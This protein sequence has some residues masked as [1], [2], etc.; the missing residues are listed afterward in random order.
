M[1]P[2]T[3]WKMAP[4]PSPS[5]RRR[6]DAA[7]GDP[8][9]P[10]SRGAFVCA[11]SESCLASSLSSGR[12]F[13]REL[14]AGRC[15]LSPPSR[16]GERAGCR[17]SRSCSLV[18]RCSKTADGIPTRTPDVLLASSLGPAPRS[19]SVAPDNS[20]SASTSSPPSRGDP[21]LSPRG[22][23]EGERAPRRRTSESSL[24]PVCIRDDKR[25]GTTL[26]RFL[27][28]ALP[29]TP[30]HLTSNPAPETAAADSSSLSSSF[31]WS[32][33]DASPC[34][35][36][37]V[38]EA[39]VDWERSFLSTPSC[40]LSPASSSSFLSAS[41]PPPA[42]L[43][44][45]P[46][47]GENVVGT[48][49]CSPERR[50]T[51][52]DRRG[53]FAAG[54][55][56]ERADDRD[57]PQAHHAVS[58]A[59]PRE[60]R[61]LPERACSV[62]EE[63]PLFPGEECSSR[64]FSDWVSRL[65]SAPRASRKTDSYR[66][67]SP[68]EAHA[69]AMPSL[70]SRRRQLRDFPSSH[71]S[72][73]STSLRRRLLHTVDPT[74]GTSPPS[75]MSRSSAPAAS[76][77]P[78]MA[79][80]SS[81][82]F[83]RGGSRRASPRPAA[84]LPP[85][86][87]RA[88]AGLASG[89]RGVA[90][91]DAEAS[92][93]RLRGRGSGSLGAR[94]DSKASPTSRLL[95]FGRGSSP[96]ASPR[97]SDTARSI[98]LS[99]SQPPKTGIGRDSFRRNA[100]TTS[101]LWGAIPGRPTRVSSA[102][103]VGEAPRTSALTGRTQTQD[104]G[105]DQGVRVPRVASRRTSYQ[106]SRY[107]ATVRDPSEESV[108]SRSPLERE[109]RTTWGDDQESNSDRENSGRPGSR[110]EPPPFAS[111]DKGRRLRSTR[112][113]GGRRDLEVDEA[114]ADAF[115][116]SARG[117]RLLKEREDREK[118]ESLQR[119]QRT[120]RR[121]RETH[122]AAIAAAAVEGQGE[123][124]LVEDSSDTL[125]TVQRSRFS[126]VCKW[127]Q[128]RFY[129]RGELERLCGEY[130]P[131]EVERVVMQ[132][133]ALSVE[134]KQRLIFLTRP[135]VVQDRHSAS[136]WEQSAS[137]SCVSL[138][139]LRRSSE[140]SYPSR[141]SGPRGSPRASGT[142]SKEARRIPD[143]ESAS[144]E[145]G[146]P[147]AFG[148][149]RGL[150]P[151]VSTQGLETSGGRD[152][153]PR[154]RH[155][156]EGDR[157]A[158]PGGR[159][160]MGSRGG[161]IKSEETPAGWS[162]D[163]EKERRKATSLRVKKSGTADHRSFWTSQSSWETRRR[164]RR[165]C[166]RDKRRLEEE[167]QTR[168]VLAEEDQM[169]ETQQTERV[170]GRDNEE[171]AVLEECVEE[172]QRKKLVR[173]T[174]VFRIGFL[175]NLA[176]LRGVTL[177]IQHLG[178]LQ[179][180]PVDSA[181]VRNHEKFSRLWGLLMPNHRL[182]GRICKEWKELGFQG[183]DP[184]TDF[185]GCGELGLD[186]LVFLASRFPSHAR[187]MLEAS[188]HSTYWY[189]FA[190]TCINVTS[191]LCEW[192]FQ[193]R[194]QVI[195]FFFTTHTPEAVE[196]TFYYL[197]VHIFTRFHEFW[198]LKKP[199]SI[200]E[201]PFVAGAFKN[202]CVLPSS[203]PACALVSPR[204]VCS[205]DETREDAWC[206]TAAL[207]AYRQSGKQP[208]RQNEDAAREK[209][210]KT[211]ADREG[212]GPVRSVGA[213]RKENRGRVGGAEEE[214]EKESEQD[215][216]EAGPGAGGGYRRVRATKVQ[217][218]GDE[219]ADRAL[220]SSSRETGSFGPS[221]CGGRSEKGMSLRGESR[222]ERGRGD[223]AQ[224]KR[225][226]SQERCHLRSKDGWEISDRK[227]PAAASNS[228]S[229]RSACARI[230][231]DAR[232]PQESEPKGGAKNLP[233]GSPKTSSLSP[234]YTML[235]KLRSSPQSKEAGAT[236]RLLSSASSRC[237]RGGFSVGGR[238]TYRRC[239]REEAKGSEGDASAEEDSEEETEE[240]EKGALERERTSDVQAGPHL[241]DCPCCRGWIWSPAHLV[242]S[243]AASS[244]GG[245]PRY[246][247]LRQRLSNRQDREEK[248]REE[249]D[250]EE[251]R[252][253]DN[254]AARGASS[255]FWRNRS[256]KQV[257]T[258]L[259]RRGDKERS[260]TLGKPS[261][262]FKIPKLSYPNAG[263]TAE[264]RLPTKPSSASPHFRRLLSSVV[265]KPE[266]SPKRAS[267]GGRGEAAKDSGRQTPYE[268]ARDE[269]TPAAHREQSGSS[270]SSL[271]SDGD[272][273]ERG[274]NR[275]GRQRGGRA[276]GQAGFAFAPKRDGSS[277]EREPATKSK[278]WRLYRHLSTSRSSRN[279]SL[280]SRRRDT[281]DTNEE[282]KNSSVASG[283]SVDDR[284]SL[285]SG[286]D[287]VDEPGESKRGYASSHSDR[288]SSPWRATEGGSPSGLGPL[289]HTIENPRL[290]ASHVSYCSLS[291]GVL[292]HS[293]QHPQGFP[294]PPLSRMI[295]APPGLSSKLSQSDSSAAS[296]SYYAYPSSSGS[297]ES[298][299]GAPWGSASAG[300]VCSA[301]MGTRGGGA[302]YSGPKLGEFT[303]PKPTGDSD[304][305]SGR[306][307][308]LS[309]NTTHADGALG[310]PSGAQQPLSASLSGGAAGA[311]QTVSPFLQ[312]GRGIAS[313]SQFSSFS[314]SAA[315]AYFTPVPGHS[316]QS[317]D[318]Q[319]DCRSLLSRF[320]SLSSQSFAAAPP[321]PFVTHNPPTGI[322]GPRSSA[323]SLASAQARL[324]LQRHTPEAGT[325][326][327]CAS[328]LPPR[329]K[330][331]GGPVYASTS[332]GPKGPAGGD[333]VK[334]RIGGPKAN[335]EKREPF[336]L[337]S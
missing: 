161:D 182:P 90:S 132:S 263:P 276:R 164:R 3:R 226:N 308:N 314:A 89:T 32:P 14:E 242:L 225:G 266:G 271:S 129:G 77:R 136:F 155:E 251:E 254:R 320:A 139:S 141:G 166:S 41:F 73:A 171:R 234:K 303:P 54:R 122:A 190:I 144:E 84:P 290:L 101:T 307:A 46:N 163:G 336:D 312:G 204:G 2:D 278:S 310:G 160:S 152:G 174:G 179:Q 22:N 60:P 241:G 133:K 281:E 187:S 116:W 29:R 176:A 291:Q 181:D 233:S 259:P 186:A 180:K 211:Q 244:V 86:A 76:S 100:P 214:T 21:L 78:L 98:L 201:F 168:A 119:G 109:A 51:E 329:A 99:S 236:S 265:K 74:T 248:D 218:D 52:G 1:R 47:H 245:S 284:E 10:A 216:D 299:P 82:H 311:R 306:K 177:A 335:G 231:G 64:A 35:R 153:G 49:L 62:G 121:E 252:E 219:K 17:A 26:N 117:S 75:R 140:S 302:L 154:K 56:A 146:A 197:F 229:L 297:K 162:K 325:P 334:G 107:T 33:R 316:L 333:A 111:E 173:N 330:G 295:S 97:P 328:P 112:R 243:P 94:R 15:R 113:A 120:S 289:G 158:P 332:P 151:G 337:L 327:M 83:G 36:C 192:L 134:D 318:P 95:N 258:C 285:S 44:F 12:L 50:A 71:S 123:A 135:S 217:R 175:R 31:C 138:D 128:H 240:E 331:P 87:P 207:T 280:S 321:V 16:R 264:Q 79:P 232:T 27:L 193:R 45:K 227:R 221:G 156:G 222:Q 38:C 196:L 81:K 315:T 114:E 293:D 238:L 255:F 250:R 309:E 118:A 202:M 96:M 277:R 188:R 230:V 189:S 43:P 200:M 269:G 34:S 108:S 304:R 165:S 270:P 205:S 130:S 282:E 235:K 124:S 239:Q 115:R 322:A 137:A 91:L 69:Y 125:L 157:D 28:S 292:L 59:S 178:S 61:C 63:A 194:A 18:F 301:Q 220:F 4:S 58:P 212:S 65:R 260:K 294:A 93:A 275:V 85:S 142:L 48:P 8:D 287:E 298:G 25:T 195:F 68:S 203:L 199:S 170:W 66:P 257:R 110:R 7:A 305:A 159:N 191:W 206:Y 246:T 103:A 92:S 288:T 172:V 317:A 183:E 39:G 24:H 283:N 319:D 185:R 150:T 9:G 42:L 55:G 253:Q 149:T 208:E 247:K 19:P 104:G 184:A 286:D 261:N 210:A 127:L 6:P 147:V 20:D 209:E 126:G 11:A 5:R 215:S 30:P 223:K 67:R 213:M 131:Q 228:Y 53:S 57:A 273:R 313:H 70:S 80:T 256:V 268:S 102:G 274:W 323:S 198:F 143:W 106:S 105:R 262:R 145:T 249:K 88:S 169:R 40:F 296:A 279:R 300:A 272:G 148:G 23:S 324:H 167:E 267:K 224:A 326:Y 37:G 72:S 13:S 237:F